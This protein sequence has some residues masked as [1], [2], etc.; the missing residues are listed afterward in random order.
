MMG[1]IPSPGDRI[2]VLVDPSQPQRVEYD[3]TAG[4]KSSSPGKS[5]A[6]IRPAAAAAPTTRGNIAE[7]LG[8]LAHL[9]DR[10]ALTEAEFDAA[11]RKL[12]SD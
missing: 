6:Q 7:E 3:K 2:S 8:K 5:F 9:R 1:E 11:K 12:L 10:G 4:T